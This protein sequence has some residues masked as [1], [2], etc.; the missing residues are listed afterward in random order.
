MSDPD[1]H[2]GVLAN[3][4]DGVLVV[5]SGGRIETINPA[6]EAILGLEPGA[7]ADAGFA[8][9]FVARDGFDDF[10][11]LILD[12][13]TREGSPERRL[14]EVEG[15]GRVR[16]LS[17][18]TSYLR[19][20]GAGGGPGSVSVIAVFSDITEMRDLQETERRMAAAAEEQHG[21]LQGAYREIEERN[22]ALA[23]ALRKVRVVQ[24]FGVLLV[25][26]VFLGVG[27]LTW[28]PFELS[29]GV[30]WFDGLWAEASAT[31]VTE[32]GGLRTFEARPGRNSSSIALK[33]RLAPWREVDVKSPVDGTIAA[34]GFRMGE[35]V[36]EGQVLLEL[37]LSKLERK[38]QSRRLAFATAE[39]KL[40]VLKDWDK[41]PEMVKARR[42]FTKARM[43]MDGRRG[44]M[45][46]S[47]F[48][49]EQGLMAAAEFEEEKR[50][51]TSQS[52]DFESAREELEAV[53]AQADDKALA[54][55][56]LA[57]EKARTEMLTAAEALEENTVRAPFSGR[58]LPPSRAGKELVEGAR[59][60]RGDSLFRIG[61]FSRIAAYTTADEIDVISLDA[62]Q[63]VT[64]TG[65]AFPGVRLNGVVD[66]VSAEAD[67][68]QKRKPVFHVAVLLD[69]LPPDRQAGVRA[70]MS[71]K[72]RIVTY[73]NPKALMV[74]L[75][76]V[77][78]RG[79]K[80]SIRVLDP[81]TG[82]VRERAVEIGPTTRRRV[83]IASG[84]K[85][86]ETVVLPAGR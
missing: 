61:D 36:A 11:Q 66:R 50:Q 54:A 8:S 18:A 9:L 2:R 47:R 43:N 25:F 48:L 79:G 68:K 70:G 13:T 77:R 20:P 56:E 16:S 80:H 32:E 6:A 46:K 59:L 52:L 3:L 37:D 22:E 55:A 12:A 53:R 44:K 14:V 41:S 78:R 71:A 73:D 82:E 39:E 19:T 85:P 28:R 69:R 5:G 60:R 4:L 40:A 10:T 63:K 64:V 75:D 57:M 45:R 7:A 23:S 24:G 1:I 27:L 34:V 65:N 51:F 33:G 21:R 58:V 26:G 42:S 35:R 62:G 38:Y 17:V 30:G 49:F 74:P 83:E 15:E 31:A 86:G 84:L 29:G 76:A 81:A 67:P 72:L